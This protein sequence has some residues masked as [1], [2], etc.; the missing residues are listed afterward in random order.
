MSDETVTACPKRVQEGGII[1]TQDLGP[2]IFDCAACRTIAGRHI[3]VEYG[4]EVHPQTA[5][6]GGWRWS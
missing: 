3:C 1:G 4:K 5:K 2:C 6:N